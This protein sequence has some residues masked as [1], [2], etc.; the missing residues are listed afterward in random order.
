MDVVKNGDETDVDCGGICGACAEGQACNVG[1]DCASGVCDAGTCAAPSCADG[2]TNGSETDVDCGAECSP[3]ADGQACGVD[4]DCTS[5]V[6]DGGACATATCSD[7]VMNQDESDVDCGGAACSGCALGAACGAEADCASAGCCGNICVD[8]QSDMSNCGGC[9]VA[10]SAGANATAACMMG[11]CEVTCAM[12]FNDCDG[13]PANG[14]ETNGACQPLDLAQKDVEADELVV[15]DTNVYWVVRGGTIYTMPKAG[16]PVTALY[17]GQPGVTC[18]AQDA[19]NLYWTLSAGA[20]YRVMKGPK[21]GGQSPTVLVAP[22]EDPFGIDVFAGDV[23]F[24]DFSGSNNLYKV[25]TM[26]GPTSVVASGLPGK[27]TD[28]L[29]DGNEFWATSANT[30]TLYVEPFGGQATTLAAGFGYPAQIARDAKYFYLG[31][32]GSA[33]YRVPVAGGALE[34]IVSCDHCEGVAVDDA[35]VYYTHYDTGVVSR[36]AKQP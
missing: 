18:I 20:L 11:S 4:A 34:P 7:G 24:M 2:V 30:G 36:I 15:D 12:G 27:N 33:I 5:L 16:G 8:L 17:A 29:V 13:D 6:C 28:V 10:C 21:A 19:T 32:Y 1:A 3:C 14:C 9:G 25:S 26:G 31:D 22:G 35:F 23:Y